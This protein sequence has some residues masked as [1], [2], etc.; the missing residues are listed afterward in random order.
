MSV[1]KAYL[2]KK[3]FSLFEAYLIDD[4]MSISGDPRFEIDSTYEIYTYT[5][6]DAIRYLITDHV[7]I[8]KLN[9]LP[10]KI[11]VV[12]EIVIPIKNLELTETLDPVAV[13]ELKLPYVNDG[14]KLSASITVT[15]YDTVHLEYYRIISLVTDINPDT[16][17]VT[18][19]DLEVDKLDDFPSVVKKK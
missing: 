14:T 16:N 1:P 11:V 8:K 5:P 6:D 13:E 10:G 15:G 18:I 4:D 17:K 12:A 2:K 7:G 19:I 9:T 3:S